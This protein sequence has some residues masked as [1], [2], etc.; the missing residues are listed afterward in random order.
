MIIFLGADLV[1]STARA[2]LRFMRQADTGCFFGANF[3][4][5]NTF[6]ILNTFQTH[7]VNFT[8]NK[9]VDKLATFERIQF[10]KVVQAHKPAPKIK[11]TSAIAF[12]KDYYVT[13]GF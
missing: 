11:H 5:I 12:A 13:L 6:K 9:L 3:W 4:A 2:Y 1:L 8:I 7:I 10:L